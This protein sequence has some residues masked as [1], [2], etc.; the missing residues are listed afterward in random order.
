MRA[1][2]I[3]IP[4]DYSCVLVCRTALYT[5]AGKFARARDVYLLMN[6]FVN[7]IICTRAREGA[8]HET[9][10]C[11]A[12]HIY[13]RAMG[14]PRICMASRMVGGKALCSQGILYSLTM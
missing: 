3:Y 1:H 10:F 13:G 4:H 7:E 12:Q 6:Q 14:A 8:M 9:P 2:R 11:S 5:C